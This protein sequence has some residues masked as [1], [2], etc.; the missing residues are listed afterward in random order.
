MAECH[1]NGTRRRRSA[2][3]QAAAQQESRRRPMASQ[4]VAGW[5]PRRAAARPDGARLPGR[6]GAIEGNEQLQPI[7]NRRHDQSRAALRPG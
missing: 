2:P 3:A 4:S 5:A 6:L 1:G 7:V